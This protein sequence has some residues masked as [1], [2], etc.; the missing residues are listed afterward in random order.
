MINILLLYFNFHI[1]GGEFVDDVDPLE[2][3]RLN[4][5]FRV[6]MYSFDLILLCTV[7]GQ[8]TPFTTVVEL[9]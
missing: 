8:E 5:Y 6:E 1:A 7:V 4:I 2:R 9:N 3:K